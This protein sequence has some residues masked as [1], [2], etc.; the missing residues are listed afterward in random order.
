MYSKRRNTKHTKVNK[1]I[2]KQ[3]T[4]INRKKKK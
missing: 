4:K 1:E 2:L 3:K